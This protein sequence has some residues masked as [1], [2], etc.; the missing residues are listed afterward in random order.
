MKVP[1]FIWFG[2]NQ[3]KMN[4]EVDVMAKYAER[5]LSAQ[6][7]SLAAPAPTPVRSAMTV[8]QESQP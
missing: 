5:L 4:L 7:D 2:K 6:L 3:P 1:Y 8:Q